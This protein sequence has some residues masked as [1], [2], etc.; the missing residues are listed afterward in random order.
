MARW[1]PSVARWD[2]RVELI[3]VAPWRYTRC[4]LCGWNQSIGESGRGYEAHPTCHKGSYELTPAD[5]PVGVPFG[6][7]LITH[8]RL[9]S[10]S[11][12]LLFVVGSI[13]VRASRR[14]TSRLSVRKPHN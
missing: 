7:F 4:G 8:S 11:P 10:L 9:P 2:E 12:I 13:S 6:E 1:D 3:E 14:V 5:L